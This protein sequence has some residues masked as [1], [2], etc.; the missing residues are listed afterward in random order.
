MPGAGKPREPEVDETVD[1]VAAAPFPLGFG[2]RTAMLISYD[3]PKWFY[4]RSENHSAANKL[5]NLGALIWYGHTR[6][7]SG[8]N[9]RIPV[10]VEAL[11]EEWRKVVV[12]LATAH[13]KD[14]ADRYEASVDKCLTPLLT[15][16]IKQIREFGRRLMETLR[17]DPAVPFLVWRSY[18]IWFERIVATAPNEEIK[19]LKTHLAKEVADLVEQDVKGQLGEALVRALQWRTPKAL[20]KVKAAV[21]KEHAAGRPARLRGRESCLF[22]EVGGTEN[23]PEVCIQI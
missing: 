16:P 19:E 9:R 2:A 14:A 1:G 23:E 22:L 8:R 4:E 6:P 11:V 20:E 12:G 3:I 7:R 13:D 15:A 18:E 21:E 10:D 5:L 17:N